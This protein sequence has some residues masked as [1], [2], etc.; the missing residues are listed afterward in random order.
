LTATIN[1][2]TVTSNEL[3]YEFMSI[4][5]GVNRVLISSS[6]NKTSVN[7]YDSV[8]I[9]FYVYNPNSFYANITISIGG[10][11][12]SVQTVDRTEQTYT[13]IAE[14]SGSVSFV[15]ACGNVSKVINFTV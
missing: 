7:Q 9:P 1:G 12:V 14:E 3:Y 4:V 8:P 11:I 13:F 5:P 15:I 6:F 2:S 10:T